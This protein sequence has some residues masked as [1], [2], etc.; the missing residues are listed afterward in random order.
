MN[1][2]M[3][4]NVKE[5]RRIGELY[6]DKETLRNELDDLA[7]E[8]K[9]ELEAQKDNFVANL[10]KYQA[11][12]S[13]KLKIPK[14]NA[15]IK[16][17]IPIPPQNPKDPTLGAIV[18][19]IFFASIP[20]FIISF[21]LK[22][23]TITIP[24]LSQIFG[25]LGQISFF[26][27]IVGGIAWFAHFA[28]IVNQYFSYKEKLNDWVNTAKTSFADGQNEYFY[29]ECIKF[30]NEFLELVKACDGYY[31]AEKEKNAIA[32]SNIQKAFSKKHDDLN[33][34]LENT[35]T[36]LSAVTLIHPDLFGSALHISKLL[37]TG[38]ADTLKEAI[39]L[40]FD[41]DRKDAEEEARQIEAARKEAILEQQTQDAREHN[42]AM[43]REAR[44][45]NLAMQAAAREQN[46][47]AREQANIAR[48]QNRLA[49]Q[50]NNAREQYKVTHAD[51]TRCYACKNYGHGCHGGI[52]NCASF[53]SKH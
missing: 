43:E 32:I 37:E 41:E 23:F 44:E 40:A 4:L 34:Q 12:Q 18:G 2:E 50:Q 52:H 1:K 48:E 33:N 15:I 49:K 35:E 39:N 10:F 6:A 8:E 30:E 45:H 22:I 21:I 14:N 13:K 5:L 25:L 24:F 3:D 27:A 38:R 19:I 46:N 47:I 26:A 53:V 42:A 7:F 29:S 36:Q 9:E 17:S 31:E 28:S 16:K 20:L 11:E 51:L